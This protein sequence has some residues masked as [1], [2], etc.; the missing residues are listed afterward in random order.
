[1]MRRD[2]KKESLWRRRIRKQAG[3]GLSIRLWCRRNHLLETSFYWWRTQLA[4][5]DAE[6]RKRRPGP[7]RKP[8]FVPVRVHADAMGSFN[9]YSANGSS[10]HIGIVLPQDRYVRVV[11][12]VDRQALSDVL[13]VLTSLSV[14][15]AE[16][17]TC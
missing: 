3:S 9:I 10:H 8:K 14:C 7:E 13:A 15:D 5:R 1:M 2:R 12:S 6:V 11:G 17:A 4:R 16:A